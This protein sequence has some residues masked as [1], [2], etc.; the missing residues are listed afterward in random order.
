MIGREMKMFEKD[1][2][3]KIGDVSLEV[4]N[5]NR[6]SKVKDVSFRLN[7][8]EILGVFGIVGSGRTETARLIFGLDK[9]ES[10]EI[11]IKGEKAEIRRPADAVARKIGFVSEDRRG[12]GLAVR[13]N[14]VQNVSMPFFK[15]FA[16]LGVISHIRESGIVNKLVKDFNI[17]TP[18]LDTAVES[19]SG[20]NQQKIVI[21]KWIGSE[22]D[23]LICDEP[24]R[25][26]DVGAKAEVYRLMEKLTSEG[27]SVIMI[28][29]ELPEVLAMSDRL[30]VFR[31]GG[32]AAEFKDV[33]SLT[34][35]DV[36]NSAIGTHA[37]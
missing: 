20:G 6:G 7:K 33:R 32:I 5:L 34:E 28:S 11:I 18:G 8:G 37:G 30:L 15:R 16:K 31:D 2:N 25:G 12:E 19:L 13:L 29:S 27:K 22:A 1:P 3:K 10:G 9:R 21:S 35:E 17:K 14:V 23:I 4:K 24:T 26:I 36:M